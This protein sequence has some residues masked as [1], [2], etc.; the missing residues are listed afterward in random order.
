MASLEFVMPPPPTVVMPPPPAPRP[1][2]SPSSLSTFSS[3]PSSP[4]TPCSPAGNNSKEHKQLLSSSS[5]CSTVVP[6]SFSPASSSS[7]PDSPPSSPSSS[8]SSSAAANPLPPPPPFPAAAPGGVSTLLEEGELYVS[9]I[10][11]KSLNQHRPHPSTKSC[12]TSSSSSRTSSSSSSARK[13]SNRRAGG[14]GGGADEDEHFVMRDADE[15]GQ[16]ATVR[17][18]TQPSLITGGQLKPY[19]M[20]G[21]NWLINLHETGL[22]GILADEMGL[23]K[24]FQTIA[25]VAYLRQFRNICGPHLVLAPKST[26]GNWQKEIEKFCPAISSVKL[27]GDKEERGEILRAGLDKFDVV[28]TSYELCIK[29]KASLLKMKFSYIIIDEAH[30]IKNDASKLSQVIRLFHTDRRLLLTGTPLQNNL[31]ELWALLNFLLPEIFASSAEFETLFDLT[32]QIT[33]TEGLSQTDRESRNMQIVQRL[34]KIL[35]PF[36]LRRVKKEVLTEMPPKKE[37]LLFVPLS[38]MQK[39]LYK[40]VLTKNVSAL[41]GGEGSARTQ[42]LNLAMQL[43]KAANHPYLFEGYEDKTLDPFGEHVV[44]NAGKMVFVDKLLV[45]LKGMGSRTLIF[46]QMTRMIDILEDFCRI[47][48]YRYCRI[49]GNT[50]GEDRDRQIEDFNAPGSPLDVFLLSTRAGGLGINLATADT[51]ILFDSDWNPQVDLQA[52]DRAHRIGQK[53]AVNVYRLVHEHTIEEK[54][55]ER[56]TMKLQLD[57][58]VIQHG[59][60]ADKHKQFGK[61]ELLSMVQYGADKIFKS[62]GGVITEADLDAILAAGR[63]RTEDLNAKIS[64]HVKRSVLDFTVNTNSGKLYEFEGVDYNEEQKRADRVAWANI[65]VATMESR[66]EREARR[67]G[68]VLK[69]QQELLQKTNSAGGRGGGGGSG[70]GLAVKVAKLPVMHEWQF[71]DKLRIQELHEKE[72]EASRSGHNN[73]SS[74]GTSAAAASAAGLFGDEQK[75]EKQRLL[76]QAF[77]DW[78]RKDFVAFIKGNELYGREDVE[79]IATEVEGKSVEEVKKFAKEFWLRHSELS[80]GDKWLKRIE[81]GEL[82]IRKRRELEQ[83]ILRRQA[84]YKHPWHELTVNYYGHKGKNVFTDEEDRW[85]LNMTALLGYGN[86]EKMKS[87][88]M[89]DPMWRFD[90]MMRSRTAAELGRRADTMLRLLKKEEGDLAARKRLAEGKQP[91]DLPSSSKR[92]QPAEQ[93]QPPPPHPPPPRS[94]AAAA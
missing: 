42:L 76:A 7:S 46:S 78:G 75:E 13:F 8:S 40:D 45:R 91:K 54:V 33:G 17:L 86:W 5:S 34:H 4:T 52:M 72:V 57:T 32:G 18:A 60:L 44:E 68:R 37:L 27:L 61:N 92:R 49:D 70:G 62:D 26:L 38:E 41:Q 3:L 59:R 39:K 12:P 67:R 14:G 15:E 83:V 31:K 82:L 20:E 22:N 87:F 24:T 10:L 84:Q 90:W 47:R 11:A 1:S 73:S 88:V 9:S 65:A 53:K 23:G 71:Y 16:S 51:V 29:E 93:P 56:A 74:G 69:E 35:K 43:R 85:I 30:R 66:D 64:S 25:L 19:Q 94:K 36:L 50:S 55:I 2:S 63:Q 79:R 77:A 81:A 89:K 48:G 80:D 21:L 28:I 6:S 58:A